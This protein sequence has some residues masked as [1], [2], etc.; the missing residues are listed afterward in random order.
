MLLG[1]SVRCMVNVSLLVRLENSQDVLCLLKNLFVGQH[2][3]IYFELV[4]PVPYCPHNRYHELQIQPFL[5]RHLQQ[6][7]DV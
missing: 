7:Y 6:L 5:M 1:S 4:P 2:A 3:S